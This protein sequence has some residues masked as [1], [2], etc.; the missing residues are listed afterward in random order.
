MT[1]ADN[2]IL[3]S[4]GHREGV[5]ARYPLVFFLLTF[6]ISWGWWGLWQALPQPAPLIYVRTAGPT[7]A[8]FV[9]LA[10][11]L[12]RP[13]VLRLLRSYVHWRVG[14]PWYVVTLIGVPVPRGTSTPP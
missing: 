4:C 10:V 7:I 14:V 6:V 8:A 1:T 13:G 5:L 2:E 3:R 12:G 9:V 11:T